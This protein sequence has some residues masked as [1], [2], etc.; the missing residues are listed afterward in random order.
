M[1]TLLLFIAQ[2]IIYCHHTDKWD[3]EDHIPKLGET[4]DRDGQRSSDKRV[5]H[6]FGEFDPSGRTAGF[7]EGLGGH[8]GGFGGFAEQN[9]RKASFG[10]DGFGNGAS[11]GS[12][13]R[14][15]GGEHNGGLSDHN[16]AGTPAR[17]RNGGVGDKGF[18]GQQNGNNGFEGQG[19]NNQ[20]PSRRGRAS[21][22]SLNTKMVI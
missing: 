7:G 15:H 12:G 19:G 21:V 14:G 13:N 8:D 17:S 18:G 4:N 22:D 6:A 9:G 11:K 5:T 20:W 10:A 2:F 1:I 16:K 3:S